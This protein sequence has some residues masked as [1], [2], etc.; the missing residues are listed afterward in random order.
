MQCW[1]GGLRTVAQLNS[2]MSMLLEEF[3]SSGDLAAA[4]RSLHELDVRPY[5]HEFVRRC[6]DA[7]Y[8]QPAQ[9]DKVV[10]LLAHMS[11]SGARKQGAC[12][13]FATHQYKPRSSSCCYVVQLPHNVCVRMMSTSEMLPSLLSGARMQEK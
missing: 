4:E 6:V 9:I 8:E 13:C 1:H 5:H 10:K 12:T 11:E 2:S 3:M 7:A